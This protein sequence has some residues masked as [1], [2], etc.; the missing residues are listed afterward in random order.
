MRL[1]STRVRSVGAGPGLPLRRCAMPVDVLRCRICESEYAATATGI[2]TKCFG[3]LEPLYDW[4]AIARRVSRASIE[5]GPR[6]LWRY[7][8][9][10]PAAP[11][12]DASAGPGWTPL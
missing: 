2:C 1:N 8:D 7:A 9:L 5:A 3:P 12:D 6:S 4:E 11:P 10:L